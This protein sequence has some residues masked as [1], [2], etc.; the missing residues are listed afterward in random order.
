MTPA[1]TPN[2]ING[3]TNLVAVGRNGGTTF[4]QSAILEAVLT[5]VE[6]QIAD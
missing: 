4:S 1:W 3:L 2:A 6:R 5:G